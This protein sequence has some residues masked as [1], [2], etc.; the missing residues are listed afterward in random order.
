MTK[1]TQAQT[2]VANR[3]ENPCITNSLPL[4]K[5]LMVV[6]MNVQ[7]E[8]RTIGQKMITLK[9]LVLA[10]KNLIV[11]ILCT[12]WIVIRPFIMTEMTF[13]IRLQF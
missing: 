2:A 12:S 3:W 4:G 10:L 13:Y 11:S 7:Q 1:P 8:C 6:R 5:S 9:T